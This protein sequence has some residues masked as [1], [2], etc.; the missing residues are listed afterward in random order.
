MNSWGNKLLDAVSAVAEMIA[1]GW[2]QPRDVFTRRMHLGPHLLAPT[3]GDLARC[4]ATA[5]ASI[6]TAASS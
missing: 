1:V 5:T 6:R 2:G 4:A 3:G